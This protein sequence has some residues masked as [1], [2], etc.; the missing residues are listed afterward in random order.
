MKVSLHLQ[1]LLSLR[2]R[3][4][5]AFNQ[6]EVLKNWLYYQQHR[7]PS[8]RLQREERR[9]AAPMIRN[10]LGLP[11][12]LAGQRATTPGTPPEAAVGSAAGA[13][14]YDAPSTSAVGPFNSIPVPAIVHIQS[15]QTAN[16]ISNPP[17]SP[18]DQDM[19]AEDYVLQTPNLLTAV[20]NQGDNH[21]IAASVPTNNDVLTL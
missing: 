13:Q 10:Q 7:K 12:L 11:R 9:A 5:P 2:R 6:A 15:Q 20:L 4:R 14:D 8:K 3:A 19:E 16:E 21:S 18:A 17:A 1:V